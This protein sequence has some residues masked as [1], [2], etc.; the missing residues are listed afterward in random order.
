MKKIY[1]RP[2]ITSVKLYTDS[3]CQLAIGSGQSPETSGDGNVLGKDY[4]DEG[5]VWEDDEY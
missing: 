1:L 4:D 5:G 3:L 2:E